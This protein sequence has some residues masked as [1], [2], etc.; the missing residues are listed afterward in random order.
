MK[1]TPLTT[2]PSLT[3]RQ[4]M[5]RTVSISGRPCRADQLQG[6]S[7]IDPA[8]VERTA[9]DGALE[10]SRPRRQKRAH[11]VERGKPSG[12]DDGNRNRLGERDRRVEIETPEHAVADDIGVDEGGDAGVLEAP[13]DVKN[14]KAGTLRPALNRYFSV[15]R[16]KPNGDAAGKIPG[17]GLDQRRITHRGSSDNDAGD[18]FAEP[19]IDGGAVANTATQLYRN[20]HR[21]ENALHRGG[22]H[23]LAGESTVEIDDV[24]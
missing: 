15:P 9:D 7:G 16:I 21:G 4:G 23:R 24:E 6:R 5:T 8:V 18:T 20:L 1:L 19:T 14:G 10:P 22:V 12:S 17:R 13:R 2:R 3:S 11:I